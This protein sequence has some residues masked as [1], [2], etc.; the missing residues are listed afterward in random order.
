[1]KRLLFLPALPLVLLL[2]ACGHTNQLAKYN[3]KGQTA[4]FRAFASGS[5]ASSEVRIENPD[6]GSGFGLLQKAVASATD[7]EGFKK[8]QRATNGDSIASAVGE[9]VRQS[10]VDYL[11]I[12]PVANG[13]TESN[14]IVETEVTDYSLIASSSGTSVHVL[15]KARVID[16]KSGEVIWEDLKSH[17]VPLSDSYF[18]T[19]IGGNV[20]TGMSIAN[21][22]KLYA[23]S[24]EQM[25]TV[26]HDAAR[27]AGK[28]I[29]DV[30][31][32]DV[33]E[34]NK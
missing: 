21:I 15:A 26:I 16:R 3:V 30:L 20:A 28:E 25:R 7:D 23:L 8:L 24:E 29:G 13:A 4:T 11:T 33:A 32:E 31:R 27:D 18:A 19:T 10:M 34:L 14:L 6:M 2:A 17:T 5:A 12:K 1:M 9:G 22:A